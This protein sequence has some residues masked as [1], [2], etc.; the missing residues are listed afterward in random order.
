[1]KKLLLFVL[2]FPQ[3]LWAQIEVLHQSQDNNSF[4]L[5]AGTKATRICFDAN[6]YE[7]VKKSGNLLATDIERVAGKKPQFIATAKALSADELIIVGTVEKNRLINQLVATKKLDIETIRGQ[8]ERFIIKTIDNPF[9]GVKKALV[10]V[11][12]DRRG[13]AYGVFSVSEAI[14]V[15]PWY[16]WADVPVAKRSSLFIKNLNYTSASPSVKYRNLYQ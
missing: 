6:D 9:P 8:W 14:G 16:W 15:S 2:C 11:G 4:P 13:T 12:S 10:I 5:V 7:V 1:M 3:V